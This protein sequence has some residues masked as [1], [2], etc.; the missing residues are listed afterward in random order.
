MRF[1]AGG[2]QK[3]KYVGTE[4]EAKSPPDVFQPS[5]QTSHLGFFHF[6]YRSIVKTVL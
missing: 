2:C 4:I 1:S 3:R 6:Y 5:W